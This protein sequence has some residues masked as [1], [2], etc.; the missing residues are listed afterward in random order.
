MHVTI[1]H[2]TDNEVVPKIPVYLDMFKFIVVLYY[3]VL[4]LIPL[5][6]TI[7]VI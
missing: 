2:A 5:S 6:P 3:F 1:T 4:D 7:Q